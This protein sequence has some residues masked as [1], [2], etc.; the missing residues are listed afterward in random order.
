MFWNTKTKTRRP[1]V[2]V[3]SKIP[4]TMRWRKTQ[5]SPLPILLKTKSSGV[6]RLMMSSAL[7][8]EEEE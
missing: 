1:K 4:S 8:S 3:P 5:K 7:S 6:Q 2:T